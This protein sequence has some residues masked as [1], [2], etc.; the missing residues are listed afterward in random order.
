M[1]ANKVQVK[2]T[3]LLLSRLKYTR[4]LVTW[5]R[6]DDKKTLILIF[7]YRI[8]FIAA[9]KWFKKNKTKCASF[10]VLL[11]IDELVALLGALVTWKLV[12]E[13]SGVGGNC[14]GIFWY[15]RDNETIERALVPTFADKNVYVLFPRFSLIQL[16]D[17]INCE[18]ITLLELSLSFK[19]GAAI[20]LFLLLFF[21]C[22]LIKRRSN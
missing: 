1:I 11:S 7:L 4:S 20:Y 3:P 12:Y 5:T 14:D 10:Y 6:F 8:I 2:R 21:F 17:E 16:D 15:R 22:A 13:Y 9:L 19:I 18:H